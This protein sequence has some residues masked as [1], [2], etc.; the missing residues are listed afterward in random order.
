MINERNRLYYHMSYD[1]LKYTL[2][3]KPREST[4]AVTPV[5]TISFIIHVHC[6]LIL[7]DTISHISHM[8]FNVF[9]QRQLD[10]YREGY[11]NLW[12]AAGTF[13]F[14]FGDNMCHYSPQ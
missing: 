5:A 11:C 13:L 6:T 8:H 9:L 14:V 4:F 1:P 3:N 10:E 12:Q 7:R 2:G